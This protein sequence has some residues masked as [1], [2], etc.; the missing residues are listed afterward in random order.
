MIYHVIRLS[1]RPDAPAE[2]VTAALGRI[3]AAGATITTATTSL[4]G[5]DIGG[6]YDFAAVSAYPDLTAYEEMLNHPLHLEVD[7][8]GLPLVDKFVSFD[9]TDDPDP[10]IAQKIAAL[11]QRRFDTQE[12]LADLVAGVDDYRGS[13]APDGARG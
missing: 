13:A 11:H 9:I 8:T 12:G 1:V 3:Q 5:R 2:E 6:E 10:Q 7:R 4:F